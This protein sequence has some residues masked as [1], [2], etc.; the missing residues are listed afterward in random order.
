MRRPRVTTNCVAQK[1]ASQDERIVE[2]YDPRTNKGGLIALRAL[3]DGTLSVEV[4]RCDPGV[5]VNGRP[6]QS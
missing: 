4:Y 1:Y 5:T 6:V 2:F 3:E